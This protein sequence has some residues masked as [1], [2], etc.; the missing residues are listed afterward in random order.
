MTYIWD[1]VEMLRQFFNDDVVRY[2]LCEFP[3]HW[4]T[5]ENFEEG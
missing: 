4:L 5:G 1:T 3:A 2:V